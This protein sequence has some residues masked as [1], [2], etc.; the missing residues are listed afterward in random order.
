[1]PTGAA[2]TSASQAIDFADANP[3]TAS[4]S[5]ML[6]PAASMRDV[7]LAEPSIASLLPD[8]GLPG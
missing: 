7:G 4:V 8:A 6:F 5:A 3:I 2:A 1:M